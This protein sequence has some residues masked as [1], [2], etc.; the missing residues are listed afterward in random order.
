MLHPGYLLSSVVEFLMV[1]LALQEHVKK[2]FVTII[3]TDCPRSETKD[4]FNR[5][6]CVGAGCCQ[7]KGAVQKELKSIKK[8]CH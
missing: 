3:P 1:T 4:G 8:S 5:L 2:V 6:P 7:E